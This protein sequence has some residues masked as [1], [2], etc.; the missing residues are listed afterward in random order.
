MAE[1]VL[2]LYTTTVGSG[3]YVSGSGT[4]VVNSATGG[5]SGAGTA[6]LL[7]LDATTKAVIL[8]FRVTSASGTTFTGASEGAD[9]NAAAGSLVYGS[10]LTAAALAQLFADHPG[11]G[12]VQTLTAPVASDFTA[13]NFNV[14][15][16]VVTTQ[17]NETS[18][19]TFITLQ[20]DD[21]THTGNTVAL[22]KSPINADFTISL[23]AAF[24][25]TPNAG[26]VM[27]IRLGDG[28]T[29]SIIFG[30]YNQSQLVIHY[31][32]VLDNSGS[33]ATGVYD[34]NPFN[35]FGPLIWLRIQETGSARNYL[36]SGDGK[37]FFP[38]FTESNT[39]HFTTA[40]Y[41]WGMYLFNG[42]GSGQITTYSF[43]ETTP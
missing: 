25:S 43:T 21:P 33:G 2:N 28:S 6:S 3:G 31:T 5:P 10:M 37:N 9:A 29:G 34:Q 36:I 13:L 14:G 40:K 27:G 32:I 30:I 35:V 39:A 19:V 12:F 22:E 42:G 26:A 4:L 15:S 20:Q 8:I 7:I 1:Q 24:M 11:S 17:D 18:P 16:S 41:G 38:V 23:G